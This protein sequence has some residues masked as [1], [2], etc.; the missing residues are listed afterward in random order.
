MWG[1]ITPGIVTA[2]LFGICV[3]RTPA[4]A[5]TGAM[6]LGVPIYALCLWALPEVAFLHHQAISFIALCAYVMGVSL[7][8]PLSRRE[9]EADELHAGRLTRVAIPLVTAAL[10]AALFVGPLARL[11]GIVLG[12]AESAGTFRD[13]AIGVAGAAVF[14]LVTVL[15]MRVPTPML[16]LAPAAVSKALCGLAAGAAIIGV[17][18]YLFADWIIHPAPAAEGAALPPFVLRADTLLAAAAVVGL[19]AAGFFALRRIPAA[20]P[21]SMP[22]TKAVDLTPSRIAYAWGIIVIA[23]VVVLYVV[24]P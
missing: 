6:L 17:H 11:A 13:A 4:V 20:A 1:F 22:V 9:G 8:V 2:F 24:F 10:G 14:G 21:R 18:A 12:G 16:R 23:A 15:V 19:F 5:A 7:L 3:A